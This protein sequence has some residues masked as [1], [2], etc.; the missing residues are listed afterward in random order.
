MA[1]TP[2]NAIQQVK[3]WLFPTILTILGGLLYADIKE[4]KDDV[5]VLIAQSAE[6]R[7][8]IE[9]LEKRMDKIESKLFAVEYP[10]SSNTPMPPT[11]IHTEYAVLVK[12]EDFKIKKLLPKVYNTTL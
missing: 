6:S 8:R 4:I 7:V 9:S 1:A 10:S 2:T 12:P 11:P 5:K 3:S